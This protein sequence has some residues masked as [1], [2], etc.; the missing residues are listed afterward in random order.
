MAIFTYSA[1][2]L[3]IKTLF[4]FGMSELRC[5]Y[6]NNVQNS[7]ETYCPFCGQSLEDVNAQLKTNQL[8]SQESVD[9]DKDL[10]GLEFYNQIKKEVDQKKSITAEKEA[11][12]WFGVKPKK[13][14][15]ETKKG[16]S[17]ALLITILGI[18]TVVSV[19]AVVIYFIVNGIP[20]QT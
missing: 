8:Q 16:F 17:R 12:F 10:Q 1:I 6:C 11:A 4:F 13:G 18:V 2:F 20:I 7:S 15:E 9:K 5:P 19:I 3:N 14:S